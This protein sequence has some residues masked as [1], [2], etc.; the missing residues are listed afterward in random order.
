VPYYLRTGKRMPRKLTEV[1]IEFRPTPHLMFPVNAE[2]LHRNRLAFRLQPREGIIQIFAAKQP[3]PDLSICPVTMDFRYDE[4]FGVDHAPRA[5][6]WLLRDAMQG[7]RT[8]FARSDWVL[9]AWRIVDPINAQ[10]TTTRADFPNHPA[11]T[12]GPPTADA[13]IQRDGREWHEK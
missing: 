8:L 13:L 12:W 11:G 10:W 1:A 9:N 3:G 6:A 7:E 2:G 4:A 5:Y